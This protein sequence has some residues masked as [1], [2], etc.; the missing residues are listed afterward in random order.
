M[1]DNQSNAGFTFG[2]SVATGYQFGT[3]QAVSTATGNLAVVGAT[4][5]SMS[6][7]NTQSNTGG[8]VSNASF[9]GNPGYDAFSSA[10]ATGNS[11]SGFACSDCGG[12]A[13]VR[14]SQTN[15]GGVSA[16]SSIAITASNRSVNASASA[17]GNSAS[18]VVSKPS[19]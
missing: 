11:V 14:T 16:T 18:F 13:D 9:G 7:D 1:A 12:G 19:H 2:Q 15:S 3:G 6:L 4:G 8:T 10:T 17:T 5:A